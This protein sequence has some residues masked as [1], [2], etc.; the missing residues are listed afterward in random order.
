MAG[1]MYALLKVAR[2]R[3]GSNG[4]GD[5]SGSGDDGGKAFRESAVAISAVLH[6]EG[7]GASLDVT[8]PGGATVSDTLAQLLSQVTRRDAS[9]ATAFAASVA[10]PAPLA[11]PG[12]VLATR[13]LRVCANPRCS[14]FGRAAEAD[15][16]LKQCAGCRAVRYCGA[17][18][19]RA[20]WPE[21][22]PACAEVKA[23]AAVAA[24]AAGAGGD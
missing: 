2:G 5:G 9:E 11:V 8:L 18:C 17:E 3:G 22:R 20:H 1:Y 23:A 19:Q 10:L 6:G 4:D 14:N 21:H 7:G 15:L 13:R 16:G 24:A 12:A